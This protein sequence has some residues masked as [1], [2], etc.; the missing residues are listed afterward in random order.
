[1]HADSHLHVM[2]KTFPINHPNDYG[3]LW[4]IEGSSVSTT[5][6]LQGKNQ[7]LFYQIFICARDRLHC[8]QPLTTFGLCD[9]RIVFNMN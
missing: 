4:A 5:V 7:R 1:M 9:K 3:Q 8:K 6:W 2:V